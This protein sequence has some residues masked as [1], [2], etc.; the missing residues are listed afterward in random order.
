MR[1]AMQESYR[2]RQQH[3][4]RLVGIPVREDTHQRLAQL[5]MRELEPQIDQTSRRRPPPRQRQ[6][7]L[8]PE[9]KRP[10]MDHPRGRLRRPWTAQRPPQLAHELLVADRVGRAGVVHAAHSLVLD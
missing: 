6:A 1:Y 5:R 3:Y 10:N 8:T 2:F 4:L 7:R 9:Q